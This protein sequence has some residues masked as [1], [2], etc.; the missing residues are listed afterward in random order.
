MYSTG[1]AYWNGEGLPQDYAKALAW[2]RRI[3]DQEHAN[4]Q[5]WLGYAYEKGLGI[6]RDSE[7]AFTWYV[8]AAAN[9]SAT[10]SGNMG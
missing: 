4:A 6:P 8:R 3:A 7:I 10:A 9:G 1:Y 2:W 5:C